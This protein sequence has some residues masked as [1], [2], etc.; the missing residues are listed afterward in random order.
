MT[1]LKDRL[2]VPDNEKW[3]L[4][5]IYDTIDDWENDYKK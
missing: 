3:K 5:D 4:T 2:Q 1:E